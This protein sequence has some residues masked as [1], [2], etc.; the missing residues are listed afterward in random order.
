MVANLIEIIQKTLQYPEL[1]KI[2]PNTGDIGDKEQETPLG[3]LA[4]S[5]IPAI[6]TG[7]YKL[8][9]IDEGCTVILNAKGN[10]DS[11]KTIFGK[12]EG[13]VVEKIAQYS[14]TSANQAQSHLE[15]IAD[16]SI[17][18]LK[19]YVGEGGEPQKLKQFMN[20]QRH[21][22][23]VYLPVSLTLGDILEDK[24]LDDQTNKME[25]PVSN[26]MHKMENK[27]SEGGE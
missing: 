6:L 22:I 9:R 8:S 17:K 12:N 19:E 27:L 14:C 10:N 23:L 2:D 4:Q 20:D 16:E 18:I 24:T 11:I 13:Q 3:L 21:N 25:G 26:F 1:K 5:S 7:L 15:N